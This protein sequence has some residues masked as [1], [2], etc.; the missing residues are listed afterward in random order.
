ML[1][2]VKK[3]I[4]VPLKVL[5]RIL[6]FGGF[7]D[8]AFLWSCVFKLT[9]SPEDG[10]NL[11]YMVYMKHGLDDA[12]IVAQDIISIS[13][14]AQPAVIIASL[15]F[16]EGNIDQARQWVQ[17]ADYNNSK[18]TNQLLVIKLYLSEFFAEYDKKSIIEDILSK[19]YLPM[20][21][22]RL[23]LVEKAFASLEEQNWKQA[24]QIA[25]RILAVEEQFV[26]R[27]IKAA[28]ALLNKNIPAAEE[29][30]TK[31]QKKTPP[32][33]FYPVA[34]HAL[35]CIGQNEMAMEYLCRVGKL[36]QRLVQSNTLI[37][38]LARSQEFENYCA[39]RERK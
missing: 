34:S 26:A 24:E 38:K 8:T 18:D 30:L 23:A 25:D 33:Q 21:V 17:L 7:F 39:K 5:A 1:E 36:D 28:L 37:G 11:L 15:E 10:T 12:R 31:A 27:I 19:N 4:A 20:E 2:F 35:L 13:K 3:I 32:N 14:S 9:A 16:R 29:L 22:T 6:G